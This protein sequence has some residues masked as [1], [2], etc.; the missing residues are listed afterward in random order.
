VALE[1]DAPNR[2]REASYFMS[3]VAGKDPKTIDNIDRASYYLITPDLLKFCQ[4]GA[5]L[6]KIN[7]TTKSI[8]TESDRTNSCGVI[9]YEAEI[10]YMLTFMKQNF[11][12]T[13]RSS[14]DGLDWIV[15]K[16]EPVDAECARIK[17][18]HG[19]NYFDKVMTMLATPANSS[20]ENLKSIAFHDAVKLV[21]K[22]IYD[23]AMSLP[24]GFLSC[25]SSILRRPI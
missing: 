21:A 5:D 1:L 23:I 6:R 20:T 13:F 24:H 22:D 9:V 17:R 2:F 8:S 19:R 7:S 12:G 11:E 3:S 15:S 10:G 4:T 16:E 14:M 18:D 25:A